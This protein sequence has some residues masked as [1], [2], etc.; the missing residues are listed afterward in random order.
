MVDGRGQDLT[1]EALRTGTQTSPLDHSGGPAWLMRWSQ[2][3]LMQ[4]LIFTLF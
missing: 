2:Y 3:A 4:T 1:C